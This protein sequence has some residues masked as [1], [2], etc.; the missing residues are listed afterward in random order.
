[1]NDEIKDA[2]RLLEDNGYRVIKITEGMKHDMDLC[3]T[4]NGDYECIEC[5]CS[6]C[7]MQ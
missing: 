3:E 1:M 4:L 2:I 6:V 5:N 7:I